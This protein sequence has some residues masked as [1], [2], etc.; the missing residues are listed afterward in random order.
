MDAAAKAAEV[1]PFSPSKFRYYCGQS[2]PAEPVTALLSVPL[3]SA[4]SGEDCSAGFTPPRLIVLPPLLKLIGPLWMV[5]L[6]ITGSVLT[7]PA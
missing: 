6:V 7:A 2:I 3:P 1:P 4:Q 5:L